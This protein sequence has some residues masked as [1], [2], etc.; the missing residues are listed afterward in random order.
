VT[1]PFDLSKYGA[2]VFDLDG[3]VWLSGDPI[4]GAIEF[5]DGLRD[6]GIK[7]AFA[8]N[9]SLSS[10][11]DVRDELIGVG[12]A[13]PGEHIVTA[14]SALALTVARSGA[15]EVVAMCS[16]PLKAALVSHGV[17]VVDVGAVNRS[18]W[19]E[20]REGRAVVLAGWPDGTLRDIETMGQL[21]AWANPMYITSLDP[22]FPG[23]HGFEPG[24]GMMVAAA[25]ALHSFE[26]T[27]CGK[28]SASYAAAVLEG[29]PTDRPIV[30]FGDSQRAD[31]AIAHLMGADSVLVMAGMSTQVV[32]DLPQPMYVAQSVAD[33][34]V[35]TWAKRWVTRVQ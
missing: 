17:A 20:P 13:R 26:P 18:D 7:V 33:V 12:L 19:M 23:K 3:T 24:A 29:I 9:I 16:P 28:P 27:V 32:A 30:M 22:G 14:G 35:T 11:E 8:T 4:P 15:T 1:A 34:A 2:A 6:Q 25:R 21:A 10:L 31:I 5:L